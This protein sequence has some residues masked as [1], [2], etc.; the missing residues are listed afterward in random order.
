MYTEE[1]FRENTPAHLALERH[2]GFGYQN[3][4]GELMY[5]FISSRPDIGYAITTLSKFSTCPGEYHFKLL[6]GV[7]RY[8]KHTINWGIRFHRPRPLAEPHPGAYNIVINHEIPKEKNLMKTFDININS[9]Q[10]KGFVDAAHANDLRKRRSTTGLVF[11]FMG[12]PVV[13]QSRTQTV[14]AGSSTEAEFFAAY[15]AGKIARYLRALLFELGFEQ[16]GPTPIYIDN[17][18]AL[19]IINDNSTPTERVRHVAIRYFALQDWCRIDKS[20]IMIHIPGIINPSD[21]YTKPL[22][23]VLHC[24]HCRRIMGHYGR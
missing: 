15:S 8:L 21:D 24:R 19:R 12:G 22:G 23:A 14:T 7:A 13:Y 11:T 4:L 9:A 1:G 2:Y 3:L 10:L 20:I 5:A 18:P 16:Q 17:E 6:K